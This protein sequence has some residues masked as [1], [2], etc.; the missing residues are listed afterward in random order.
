MFFFAANTKILFASNRMDRRPLSHERLLTR[1]LG[2]RRTWEG[3]AASC[4]ENQGWSRASPW[5]HL[6]LDNV[7]SCGTYSNLQIFRWLRNFWQDFFWCR[8][9]DWQVSSPSSRQLQRVRSNFRIL[10]TIITC[11]F[12]RS[13]SS[14]SN[15][16]SCQCIWSATN[17]NRFGELC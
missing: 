17:A 15:P 7:F 13:S 12:S 1:L 2:I 14:G 6:A 11:F 9:E 10:F 16:F 4:G 5:M 8:I 3:C